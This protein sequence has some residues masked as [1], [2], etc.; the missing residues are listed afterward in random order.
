MDKTSLKIDIKREL[1][2]A[3]HTSIENS[4]KNQ[5]QVVVSTYS[6]IP[7][8]CK[9]LAK[10]DDSV[11]VSLSLMIIEVILKFKPEYADLIE[12][13][14]GFDT[15]ESL[16]GGEHSANATRIHSNCF[17]TVIARRDL[18]KIL[19]EY[20]NQVLPTVLVNLIVTFTYPY[21]EK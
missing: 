13:N 21:C 1:M 10:E 16:R 3:L 15:I 6:A 8:L 18:W 7:R 17:Q 5:L 19:N 14:G 9:I 20:R 11:V 4:N 12:L 2:H